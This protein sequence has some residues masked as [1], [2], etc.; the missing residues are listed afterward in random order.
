MSTVEEQWLS[1]VMGS[2]MRDFYEEIGLD[3][4][5]YGDGDVMVSCFVNPAGHSHDDSNKSCSV[6]L[7]TGLYNCHGCGESGNAYQA[8]VAKGFTPRNAM[9]LLQRHGLARE[10]KPQAP[11]IGGLRQI[12]RWVDDLWAQPRLIKRLEQVKGWTPYAIQRCALG[13][14]GERITF[15]IRKGYGKNTKI[16]GLVRYLPGADDK[17]ISA[18]G[19]RR[20]LFP[21]P[22]LMVRDRPLFVVE[23]EP[24]AVSVRSAGHQAVAVPG[25]KSWR[26]EMAI[27][28]SNRKLIVLCDCDVDGRD[29]AQ[30]IKGTLPQAHVVDLDPFRDDKWDVGD[31]VHEATLEGGVWQAQRILDHFAEVVA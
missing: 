2:R 3:L 30:R 14:D 6:N 25:V 5:A 26:A 13:W 16:V 11:K 10:D 28:L 21:Q 4:P 31:L 12:T 29:L 17:M 8:A 7:T 20:D 18:P 23:G 19:T 22:E 27:R 9:K 24:D 15:P 1:G